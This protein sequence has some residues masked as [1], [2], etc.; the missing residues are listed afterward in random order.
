MTEQPRSFPVGVL[1]VGIALIAA[2]IAV[3]TL[4]TSSNAE[5]PKLSQVPQFSLTSQHDTPVNTEDLAGKVWVADLIFTTCSGPCLRM[6]SQ[7]YLVQEAM[8]DEPNFRMVSISVDPK[9]DTPERLTW[10]AEQ[11]HADADKWIFLTGDMASIR[12]LA[13]E[14]FKLAVSKGE[15]GQPDP[16][17]ILHSEKFV[18]VDQTGHIRGYYDGLDKN[19]LNRLIDDARA[20]AAGGV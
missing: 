19:D 6:T 15:D 14:G 16:N 8:Q 4:A 2:T 10:Y 18:L 12:S 3:F 13:M 11:A 1:I 17:A 7:M 9:R 20:L 5:L